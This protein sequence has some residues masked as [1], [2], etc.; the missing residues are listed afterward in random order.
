M[1]LVEYAEV[2]SLLLVLHSTIRVAN[3]L[4]FFVIMVRPLCRGVSLV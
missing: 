3:L 2:T 4:H 1:H